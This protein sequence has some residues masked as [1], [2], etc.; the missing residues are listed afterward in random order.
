T[1]GRSTGIFRCRFS[2]ARDSR[3]AQRKSLL[4]K[5]TQR[6]WWDRCARERWSHTITRVRARNHTITGVIRALACAREVIR[7]LKSH[8]HSR[9]E[10]YD[11]W[12]HTITRARSHTITE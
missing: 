8:D 12:S 1:R 2:G 11:H 9:A 4:L 7:S 10:S 3:S 5:G 6:W